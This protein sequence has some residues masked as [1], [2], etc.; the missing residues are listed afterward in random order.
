VTQSVKEG[1]TPEGAKEMLFALLFSHTF[2]GVLK[3]KE[4]EAKIDPIDS[5]KGPVENKSPMRVAG[6]MN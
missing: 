1:K 5:L 2:I 3:A 6:V 4:I